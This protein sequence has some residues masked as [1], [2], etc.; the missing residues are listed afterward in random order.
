LPTLPRRLIAGPQACIPLVDT[1][2]DQFPY[3]VTYQERENDIK[4]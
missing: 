2:S 3:I 4:S 1:Y